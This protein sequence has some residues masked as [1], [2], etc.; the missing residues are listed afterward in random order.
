MSYGVIQNCSITHQDSDILLPFIDDIGS[1]EYRL[2]NKNL[3][4]GINIQCTRVYTPCN[5]VVLQSCKLLDGFCIILQYSNEICLR[6]THLVE[7]YV[8]AG[9]LIEVDTEIGRCD[10]F[11]HFEYLRVDDYEPRWLVRIGPIQLYK[12]NPNDVFNGEISFD[13]SVILEYPWPEKYFVESYP[14]GYI[15]GDG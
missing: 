9:Q 1:P 7:S 13:N 2:N 14:P 4:D 12:H 8:V 5:A 10:D 11:V 6:F 15:G 3:H